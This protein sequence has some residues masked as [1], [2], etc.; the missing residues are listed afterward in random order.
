MCAVE[1]TSPTL[2]KQH[3]CVS[4]R[5]FGE[6]ATGGVANTGRKRES[7]KPRC[8][9]KDPNKRKARTP[10]STLLPGSAKGARVVCSGAISC[11][12]S[13]R[14]PILPVVVKRGFVA[15]DDYLK[16]RKN[17]RT[18]ATHAS[19]FLTPR[20]MSAKT[21]RSRKAHGSAS[22]PLSSPSSS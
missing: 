2:Q 22:E 9:A 1:G 16:F 10:F 15:S 17:M 21:K 19:I 6:R 12:L 18:S 11:G 13:L 14:M 20:T 5:C 4:R 3:A 8:K 7:G